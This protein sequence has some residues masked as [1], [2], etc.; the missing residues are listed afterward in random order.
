MKL[1]KDMK[2]SRYR[3]P[4]VLLEY[5]QQQASA[6]LRSVNAEVVIRLAKSMEEDKAR[7]RH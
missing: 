4:E 5:L 7:E 2:Q 6:N 3:M 1:T